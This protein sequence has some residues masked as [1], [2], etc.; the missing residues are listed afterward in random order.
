MF[1]HLHIQS[2]YSLLN[3]TV[4][5]EELVV[6]AKEDGMT[7]LALCDRNVMYGSLYFYKECQ[8]IG[9]K[10]IIGLL[11]DVLDDEESAHPLILLAENLQGYQNLLKISSAIQT[12]S[13]NGLPRNWLR[14]YSKGLIAISPG[15]DGKIEEYLAEEKFEEATREAKELLEVFGSEQFY[16][17]IQRLNVSGEEKRNHAVVQLAKQIGVKVVAT[18]PVY[19]LNAN[20]ALAHEVLLAVGNGHKLS[21][22]ERIVLPSKQFYLKSTQEMVEQFADLPDVLENTLYIASQCNLDIPFHQLLLPKY[23]TVDGITSDDMLEELC[24]QGLQ[25]RRSNPSSTYEERLHYELRCY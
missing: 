24:W 10:P 3:S 15:V 22:E 7:S 8:K 9:I 12:K 18:N 5:I 25:S 17:S 13:P 11:S 6:Q 4:K 23:P 1:T 16:L 19:Y 2:G 20:D 21:E 14:A